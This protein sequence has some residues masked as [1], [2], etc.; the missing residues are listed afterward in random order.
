MPV[1]LGDG[2]PLLP[3]GNSVKLTL[4]DLKRLP[5]SGIVV[6]AYVVEHSKSKAPRV[7]YVKSS[8]RKTS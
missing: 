1:L 7:R 8:R 6:L 4:V 3:A 5:A 2:I